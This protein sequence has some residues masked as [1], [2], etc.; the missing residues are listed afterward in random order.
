[1][2]DR[3]PGVMIFPWLQDT[4]KVLRPSPRRSP[5]GFCP[6]WRGGVCSPPKGT[7]R[8]P[9]FLRSSYHVIVGYWPKPAVL[10]DGIDELCHRVFVVS[11]GFRIAVVNHRGEI[12]VEFGKLF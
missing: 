12:V 2:S 3:T 5:S 9:L 7:L 8:W 6:S 11:T 4:P 1:M 10:A